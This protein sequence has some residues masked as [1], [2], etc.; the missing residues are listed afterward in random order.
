MGSK[1]YFARLFLLVATTAS[2]HILT[3]CVVYAQSADSAARL[4]QALR[5]IEDLEFEQAQGILSSAVESGSLSL[6][7]QVE[8]YKYMGICHIA[9]GNRDE[10]YRNFYRALSLDRKTQLDPAYASSP[11]YSRVFVQAQDALRSLDLTPPKI[12]LVPVK[13]GV[14]GRSMQIEAKVTDDVEVGEV[15]LHYRTTGQKSFRSIKMMQFMNDRYVG[16]IPATDVKRE[17]VQY[18]I[19]AYDS[20]ER[21]PAMVGSSG[22]PRIALVSP[23]EIQGQTGMNIAKY[24]TL[25]LGA[26]GVGVGI[27]YTISAYL[28][29]INAED[30]DDP[31]TAD[32]LRDWED[33]F[34]KNSYIGYGVGGALLIASGTLFYYDAK[35][36][37]ATANAAENFEWQIFPVFHADGGSLVFHARF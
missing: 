28:T 26:T 23:P 5:A 12:D 16:R 4:S 10:G 3:S 24:S 17:G 1:N 14:A 37:D 31:D 36:K 25:G 18:Y 19:E 35:R 7:E 21:P 30:E 20:T 9:L 8:A 11:D 22:S 33:R 27:Y 2:I 15:I 34:Y 13:Q 29:G 6:I 32:K